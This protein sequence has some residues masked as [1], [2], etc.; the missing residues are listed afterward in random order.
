MMVHSPCHGENVWNDEE[1]RRWSLGE[2][3]QWRLPVV[4]GPRGIDAKV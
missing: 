2:V 1:R 3:R 4:N